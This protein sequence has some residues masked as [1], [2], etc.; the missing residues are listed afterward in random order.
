MG[1]KGMKTPRITVRISQEE[2]QRIDKLIEAKYFQDRSAFVRKA[3]T[4]L[5]T[6]YQQFR[7]AF[8]EAM[9]EEREHDATDDLPKFVEDRREME[10]GSDSRGEPLD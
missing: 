9:E 1:Q 6:H 2:L 4:K 3:I 8:E 10:C 5:L 7:E